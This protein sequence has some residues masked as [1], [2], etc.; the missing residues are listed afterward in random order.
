MGSKQVEAVQNSSLRHSG[1]CLQV[2]AELHHTKANLKKSISE[3]LAALDDLAAKHDQFEDKVHG[4]LSLL[5]S[6]FDK[7]SRAQVQ[8]VRTLSFET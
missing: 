2:D 8:Q 7:V 5:H 4:D 1:L 3:T 6:K